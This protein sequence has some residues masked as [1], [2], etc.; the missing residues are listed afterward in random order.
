MRAYKVM[1][2]RLYAY[3]TK[4]V[5]LTLRELQRNFVSMATHMSRPTAATRGWSCFFV[6]G[7]GDWKFKKEWLQESRSYSHHAAAQSTGLICR[8]CSTG[9][10][11]RH[12]LDVWDLKFCNDE[13]LAE[14]EQS[15]APVLILQQHIHFNTHIVPLN[16]CLRLWPRH[17]TTRLRFQVICCI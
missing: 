15:C 3:D 13:E 4:G 10:P 7:K 11:G 8:R 1:P 6:A 17:S 14:A 5:N 9:R 2:A 12:F 16:V